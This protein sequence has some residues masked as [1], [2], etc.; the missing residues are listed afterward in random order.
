[1]GWD[2]YRDPAIGKK[3]LV[4]SLRRPSR[5]GETRE[6]LKACTA[7]NHH[8]YLVRDK[9]TG[10]VWIG[11]DLLQGGG[12]GSGW[13][14]KGM[15]E[16]C[17]PCYYDCPISYLDQASPVTEGYAVEW[18]RK[19]REHRADK[20][21]RPTP[22]AGQVVRYGQ[23]EYR[24]LEPL[25]PRRGWWVVRVSDGVRFR[26]TARQLAQAVIVNAPQGEPA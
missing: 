16:H 7:G 4:E 5:F 22:A 25:A 17:G 21:A 19:V 6:L 18:R 9:A 3:Q 15:T 1:M 10:E 26:M 8:W 14:Y 13:G 24:L 20:K 2:F 12:P 11:L 23:H